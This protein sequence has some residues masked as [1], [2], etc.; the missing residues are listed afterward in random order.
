MV[1]AGHPANVARQAP[2]D[3]AATASRAT[4]RASSPAAAPPATCSRAWP[5]PRPWSTRGHDRRRDPLR[6]QRAGHRG[7]RSCPQAGFGLDDAPRAGHPAPARRLANLGAAWSAWSRAAGPGD[8]PRAPPPAGGGAS[9]SAGYASVACGAGRRAAGAS[10]SCVAEQNARAGRGQPARRPLRRAPARCPFPGTDLPRAVVTG[11]PVRPEILAVDRRPRPRR[12]PARAR[13]AGRPH[14]RRRVRRLAR[15]RGAINE[16]VPRRWSSRWADRDRPRRPPRRR[17]TR[18]G[19]TCGRGP[20]TL[21]DGR[22]RLPGGELRGPHGPAARGR[23]PRRQPG[24]RRHGRRAGRGRPAGGARAAARSPPRDHQT[25][26][27]AA[28]AD[29]GAAVLVPDAELDAD[30]LERRAR[31]PSST[32]RPRLAAMAGG[33]RARWPAPTPPS[34][35]ADLVEEHARAAGPAGSSTST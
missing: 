22:A 21:P 3:A 32:T 2:S 1:A 29:A 33:A 27:A 17:A 12:G 9:R 18:L 11:N 25:A 31:A 16:A 4:C 30:R 15:R 20:P 24:R 35:V 10:R 26:N 28:L 7:R 34:R 14:G 6:R 23:R 8:R 5:W 19:P 13:P